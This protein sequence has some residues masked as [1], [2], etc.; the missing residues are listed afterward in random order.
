MKINEIDLY[1]YFGVKKPEN[2]VGVIYSYVNDNS[3]EI[4]L[5][6]KHPAMLVIPGGGYSMTS[7]RE[8]EPVALAYTAKNFNSFVLRYSCSP[9]RHPYQLA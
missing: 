8:A 4:E 1:E 7:D 6:R 2:G 9:V 5:E 3:R